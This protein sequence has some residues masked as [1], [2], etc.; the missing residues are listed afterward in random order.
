[1]TSEKRRVA[2]LTFALAA[3]VLWTPA[4]A[5]ALYILMPGKHGIGYVIGVIA[6]SVVFFT[7]SWFLFSR[8]WSGGER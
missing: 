7:L 8:L 4:T 2:P 6:G 3:S 5:V 1:M